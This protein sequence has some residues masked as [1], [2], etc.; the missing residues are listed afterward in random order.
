MFPGNM[1]TE[2]AGRGLACIG[3]CIRA[4]ENDL[5]WYFRHNTEN[6][7]EIVKLYGHLNVHNSVDPK[8]FEKDTLISMN[9]ALS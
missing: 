9:F 5:A 3:S 1:Y 6:M 7:L 4:E 8:Q 2:K